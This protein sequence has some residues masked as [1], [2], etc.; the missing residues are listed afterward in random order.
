M[1][2]AEIT[3]SQISGLRGQY[4]TAQA[5]IMPSLSVI[6]KNEGL[7]N[8]ERLQ[9]LGKELGVPTYQVAEAFTFYTIY[10]RHGRGKHH[11]QICRNISCYVRGCD[12]IIDSVRQRLQLEHGEMTADQKFEL[13]VVECL[14]DCDH[15]PCGL[16]GRD[17]L[18]NLTVDKINQILSE[19]G[20]PQHG[21]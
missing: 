18:E 10:N 15:A 1:S 16:L 19:L 3:R 9:A 7:I 14:G 20:A 6:E 12:A 17:K 13:E 11:L 4:A 5:C 2:L 8:T 21:V